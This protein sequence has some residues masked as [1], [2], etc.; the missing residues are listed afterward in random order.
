M[1][2]GHKLANYAEIT[3]S[4]SIS[5][6]VIKLGDLKIYLISCEAESVYSKKYCPSHLLILSCKIN[7]ITGQLILG[8]VF[9]FLAT[10]LN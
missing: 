5:V 9:Q 2:D 7:R 8:Q 4:C 1:I 3:T 6:A 10:V